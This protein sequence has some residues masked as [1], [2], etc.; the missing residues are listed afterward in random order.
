MSKS[1]IFVHLLGLDWP[2][3]VANAAVLSLKSSPSITS[4]LYSVDMRPLCC[5]LVS[6]SQLHCCFFV[7]S[8]QPLA[9]SSTCSRIERR[10]QTQLHP[11]EQQSG[12]LGFGEMMR[13]D[14]TVALMTGRPDHPLSNAVHVRGRLSSRV[15]KVPLAE[16]RRLFVTE[17]SS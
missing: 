15:T 8:E 3:Q 12:N 1:V 16:S 13:N 14:F 5:L 4:C 9:P 10:V 6:F 11:L 2:F 7:Q 17:S